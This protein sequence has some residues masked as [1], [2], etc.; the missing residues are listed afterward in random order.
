MEF[1]AESH[2]RVVHFAIA[3]LFAYPFLESAAIIF[4]NDF[5]S[6]AAHLF[7][8]FGVLGATAAVLTGEQALEIARTWEDKGAIIQFKAIS[9][10]EELA[11][12]TLWYFFGVLILR[13]FFTFKKKFTGRIKY[14]FIILAVAGLYLVFQTG[15]HGGK[16]VYKYGIGTQYKKNN[17]VE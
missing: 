8:F 3:F 7:L 14:L 16:L 2:P 15:D 1:L 11:N 6:K 13:T 10:H 17:E 12:L 5:L 9:E 4:K